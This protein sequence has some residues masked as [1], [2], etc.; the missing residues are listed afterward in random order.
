MIAAAA[1]AH[2]GSDERRV[3]GMATA[4][5]HRVWGRAQLPAAVLGMMLLVA[6]AVW[7]VSAARSLTAD[8]LSVAVGSGVGRVERVL[9]AARPQHAMPGMGSDDDPVAE[10]E[11]R[12]TVELTL[13]AGDEV[14]RF[15]VS[16]FALRVGEGKA[17]APHRSLLPETE[18][19]A[20]TTLSGVLVFDVPRDATQAQLSY[21]GGDP[22]ELSLPV[23]AG[24]GPAPSGSVHPSTEPSHSP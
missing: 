2:S 11:R 3:S 4:S 9:S 5:L 14:L 18:M 22:V 7:S 10:D 20:G 12:V 23:E 17:L 24:P 1:R 19:P 13:E 16:G 6:A 8:P 21:D 15:S